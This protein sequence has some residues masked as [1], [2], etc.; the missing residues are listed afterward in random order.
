MKSTIVLAQLSPLSDIEEN[1][2]KAKAAVREACSGQ[3]ADMVVFPESFMIRIP[4]H[5]GIRSEMIS[6]SGW[7]ACLFRP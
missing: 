1:V 4:E 5:S 6:P 7:T 3:R 2:K